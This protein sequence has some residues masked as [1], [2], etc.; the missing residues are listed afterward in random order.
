MSDALPDS[1]LPYE[2]WTENALR[3]VVADALEHVGR[4][5]LPGEH[6][7]YISFR[8]DHPG[9]NIPAHLRARYPREITIILQHRF[10]DLAVDRAAQRFTVGLS[11][12][13]VPAK[14]EVPLAALTA[15]HDPHVRF[16]L[17]FEAEM[18]DTAEPAAEAPAPEAAPTPAP[19]D[20]PKPQVVSLE[21][22]RRKRD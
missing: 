10:W 8:T 1:L 4:E 2:R 22:F 13:G 6:H 20:A 11:F 5:G 15:F 21:A 18:D 9:V 3:A 19:E 7:F 12:G 14:L 16:G 17:R